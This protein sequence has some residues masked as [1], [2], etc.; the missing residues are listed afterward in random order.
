MREGLHEPVTVLS[1]YSHKG[2]VFRP[3]IM[4]WHGIDYRLGPVDFHHATK[5]GTTTLH[6]FS[7][8]DKD[9]SIYVKLL[10]NA[11]TLIWTLEEYMM[12]G[13]SSVAY[14]SALS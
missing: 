10:F 5:Q 14:G 3:M 11:R 12:A 2:H 7:L 4:T 9:Q 1:L 8:A 6:H 13:E